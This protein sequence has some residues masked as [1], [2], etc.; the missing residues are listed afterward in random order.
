MSDADGPH[1]ERRWYWDHR[2][3]KA[4]YPK[5][6]DDEDGTVE[7]VTVWHHGEVTDA[8]ETGALTPVEEVSDPADE[9][10]GF[11]CFDSFRFP[12]GEDDGPDEHERVSGDD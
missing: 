7:L 10:G 6:V 8:L 1:I 3:N 11:G 2:T 9:D 12:V 4:Y 5:R